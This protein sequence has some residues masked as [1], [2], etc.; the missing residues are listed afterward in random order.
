M[1]VVLDTIRTG[2]NHQARDGGSGGGASGRSGDLGGAG[3]AG[4]GYEGASSTT[5]HYCCGGGGASEAG[6]W[7]ANS[8][9]QADGGDGKRSDILGTTNIIGPVVVGVRN[10][11]T[12][13]VQ[14][15]KGV[16]V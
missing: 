2:T 1:G 12:L 4:Q 9:T 11:L 14:V 15:V 6:T 13:K 16:V 10:T 5:S 3:T 7:G 8:S